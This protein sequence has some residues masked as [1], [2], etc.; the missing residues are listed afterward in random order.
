MG[1]WRVTGSTQLQNLAGRSIIVFDSTLSGDKLVGIRNRMGM[2]FAS[3]FNGMLVVKS[4]L[5]ELP[6]FE[7]A[8]PVHPVVKGVLG[9]TGPT[10][11]KKDGA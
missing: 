9:V 3:Q 7:L 11:I 5:F 2:K 1:I 10:N 6:V 8:V 4:Q